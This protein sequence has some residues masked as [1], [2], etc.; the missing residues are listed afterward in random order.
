MLEIMIKWVLLMY[1]LS[2]TVL[3]EIQ[4]FQY[5]IIRGWH[6][7]AVINPSLNGLRQMTVIIQLNSLD[8]FVKQ[9]V[10]KCTAN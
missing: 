5:I 10:T 6:I 2:V 9:V 8:T 4:C 1:F 7:T 3:T